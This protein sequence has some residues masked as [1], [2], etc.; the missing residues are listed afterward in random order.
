MHIFGAEAYIHNISSAVL[1]LHNDKPRFVNA[2]MA[3]GILAHKSGLEIDHFCYYLCSKPSFLISSESQTIAPGEHSKLELNSDLESWFDKRN[4]T[5]DFGLYKIIRYGLPWMQ[6]YFIV[7]P[8]KLDEVNEC[9]WKILRIPPRLICITIN[10]TA[11]HCFPA[12][13]LM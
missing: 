13:K 4:Q 11:W 3:C 8:R 6:K 7:Q 1:L 2:W 5:T 9:V 10:I 12:L